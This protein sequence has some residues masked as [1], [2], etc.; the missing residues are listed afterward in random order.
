MEAHRSCLRRDAI[1]AET[2][3]EAIDAAFYPLTHGPAGLPRPL[4]GHR[5]GDPSTPVIVHLSDRRQALRR[6]RAE[7]PAGG[8]WKAVHGPA[9][10]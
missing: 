7:M 3:I 6:G 10:S 1:E 8:N 4:R 9:M 5:A 2:E